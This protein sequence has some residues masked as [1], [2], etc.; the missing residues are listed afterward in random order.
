MCRSVCVC[1]PQVCKI[2]V[3]TVKV[4]YYMVTIYALLK[5]LMVW[6]LKLFSQD[7]SSVVGLVPNVFKQI[8]S[9][10]RGFRGVSQ[11]VILLS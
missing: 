7:Q 10:A 11:I 6:D 5:P 9:H 2:Y 4:L 8:Q 1:A 3:H